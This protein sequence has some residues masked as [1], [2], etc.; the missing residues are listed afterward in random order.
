MLPDRFMLHT[1]V[2]SGLQWAHPRTWLFALLGSHGIR[3]H[4]ALA[5][6][7]GLSKA[8]FRQAKVTTKEADQPADQG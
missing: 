1:F 6:A 7:A 2:C 5:N 4:P 3:P 8:V